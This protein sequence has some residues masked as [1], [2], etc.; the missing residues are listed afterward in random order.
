[1]RL[2]ARCWS[3]RER[4]SRPAT[5]L[6]SFTTTSHIA[7]SKSLSALEAQHIKRVLDETGWNISQ[8]ARWLEIDRVTLYNKINKYRF[9][10][11]GAKK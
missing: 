10:H 6:F 3:A 9:R 4:K 2:S 11:E 8:A 1:M 7:N 5:C